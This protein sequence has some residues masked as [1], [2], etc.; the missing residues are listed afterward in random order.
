M[1]PRSPDRPTLPRR[2]GAGTLVL[3]DTRHPVLVSVGSS[4]AL[5]RGA[6]S[7]S[8]GRWQ[9]R[10]MCCAASERRRSG[11][12]ALGRRRQDER[13]RGCDASGKYRRQSRPRGCGNADRSDGGAVLPGQRPACLGSP[14]GPARHGSGECP[15]T[16]GHRAG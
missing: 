11:R 2:V 15:A 8:A 7:S 16:S 12:W 6:G 9:R 3:S 5:G 1:A 14:Q 13:Y 4:F 10:G